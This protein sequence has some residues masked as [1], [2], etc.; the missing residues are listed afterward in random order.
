MQAVS[1]GELDGLIALLSDDVT[2]WTDGGGKV[3]GAATQTLQGR[4][5]VAQFVLASTRFLASDA[6]AEIAEVNGQP[7]AILRVDRQAVIIIAIEVD[8]DHVREI[9]VIGN[10]DKLRAV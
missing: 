5:A 10:P 7:A 8:R 2:M 3:R 6:H 9:R 1:T 4:T